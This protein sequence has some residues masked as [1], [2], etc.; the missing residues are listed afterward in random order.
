MGDGAGVLDLAGAGLRQQESLCPQVRVL[1][2]QRAAHGSSLVGGHGAGDASARLLDEAAGLIDAVDDVYPWGGNCRTPRYID[3]QRAT[4]CARLGRTDEAIDL[5]EQ[6]IPDIPVSSRRDLGVY[7]ARQAH[8]L[9]AGGE[10]EQAVAI[11][12]EVAPLVAS[13]GSARMRAELTGL[14]QPMKPWKNEPP[15]RAL[16]EVL[17]G[18]GRKQR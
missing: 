8:A 5:W 16:E 18:I 6:V 12:R 17:A 4:V 11:A 3:V 10:P 2:L 7:R 1:L 15:G 9:A 14:R 13:T